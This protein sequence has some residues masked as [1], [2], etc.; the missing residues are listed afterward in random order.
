M[1]TTAQTPDSM[2]EENRIA[3][4]LGAFLFALVGG[5][6]YFALWQIGFVA[7]ISGA[8][9]VICA[10]KGYKLFAKKES[11]YG[12][13]TSIVLAVLVIAIAWYFCLAFDVYEA[14]KG[15]Y[16]DGEIDA[17]VSFLEALFGAY[18]FLQD[19][20]IAVSYVSNLVIGVALCAVGCI[21]PVRSAIWRGRK[22]APQAGA[23]S[24]NPAAPETDTNAA[25]N[26][27][28]T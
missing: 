26:N 13:V 7:A 20:D 2:T 19:P 12:V 27:D 1:N 9:A 22:P 17:P 24:E 3:G 6:V 11:L 23:Q 18:L 28:Q 25:Q 14:Y 21:S 15:W 4:T 8:I 16:A 5:L 10:M